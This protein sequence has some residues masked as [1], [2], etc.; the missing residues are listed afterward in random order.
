MKHW[1]SPGDP[2]RQGLGAE[3]PFSDTTPT[4]AALPNPGD[5]WVSPAVPLRNVVV[6]LSYS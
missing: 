6:L 5:I 4:S 3:S 1:V 2:K